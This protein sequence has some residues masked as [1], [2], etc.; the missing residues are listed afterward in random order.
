MGPDITGVRLPPEWGATLEA[1]LKVDP[2][3]RQ[4]IVITGTSQ[5]DRDLEAAA[6]E[7]LGRYRKRVAL[8][9]LTG[10]PMAQQLDA[11][12]RLPKDSIVLFVSLL[13]D[14]TGR[15]FT[16]PE[17]VSLIAR[18]SNVPVYG[19]SET[20]LGHGI[21][22]GRLTSFEAQGTR[23]AELGLRIL[24]GGAPEERARGRRR[25]SRVHLRCPPAPTL[26][27]R[28]EPASA[29]EHRA[30]SGPTA[31]GALPRLCGR[32]GADP[33]RDESHVGTPPPAGGPEARRAVARRAPEVREPASELSAGLIHVSLNDLDDEIG[34]G[35]RQVGGFPRW[36]GPISTNTSRMGLSFV[37]HGPWRGS[38]RCHG[39][40]CLISSPGLPSSFGV[41]TWSGPPDWTSFPSK[42]RSTGRVVR[43]AARSQT[44]RSRWAPGLTSGRT[45]L[46]FCSHREDLAGRAAAAPPAPQRGLRGHPGAPAS[47]VCAQRAAALRS[48]PVG[49][50]R[51]VQ[52]LTGSHIRR[53]KL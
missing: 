41:D 30:V 26:G 25:G 11:V 36:I 31:V 18:A 51:R 48:S 35:L 22:G 2:R 45:V 29:G 37:S 38:S 21:V 12:A 19:W 4:V 53:N 15:L 46:R 44:C 24:R 28:R 1:A 14:G 3:V 13:R 17:A 47:G 40:W 52:R 32:W 34:R 43:E 49:A 5:I 23:A 8:T 33:R 50:V 20:H 27:H 6:A 9:Y 10:L 16:N 7:D 39:S 42:P